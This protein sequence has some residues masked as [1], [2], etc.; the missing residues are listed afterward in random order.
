[1]RMMSI[2]NFMIFCR[3]F[4]INTRVEKDKLVDIFKK[5]ST[6]QKYLTV[7][8]F[9]MAIEKISQLIYRHQPE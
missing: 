1:M 7:E 8:Q 6:H 2:T 4:K 3:D 5:N 9:R